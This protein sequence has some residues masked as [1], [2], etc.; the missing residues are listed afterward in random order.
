MKVAEFQTGGTTKLR[1]KI[2]KV[3]EFQTF[4]DFFFAS[5]NAKYAISDIFTVPGPWLF[6]ANTTGMTSVKEQAIHK[7]GLLSKLEYFL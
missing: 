4:S 3:A 1:S 5:D 6:A 7:S 2:M